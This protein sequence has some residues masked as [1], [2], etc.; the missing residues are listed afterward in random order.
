MEGQRET[1]L[2]EHFISRGF[3]KVSDTL[4]HKVIVLEAEAHAFSPPHDLLDSLKWDGTPRL[5]SFFIDH[6]GVAVEG[7]PEL[8]KY[9]KAVTRCFFIGVAAR[10]FKP[11]CKHDCMLILEGLQGN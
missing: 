11:G 3:K 9:V 10:T 8:E 1:A 2:A 6:C 5:S 7:D 4:I